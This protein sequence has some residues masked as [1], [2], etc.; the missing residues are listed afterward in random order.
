M[1]NFE[2]I[3]FNGTSFLIYTIYYVKEWSLSFLKH[4]EFKT[5]VN[6]NKTYLWIKF[7]IYVEILNT[8]WSS[9]HLR[10]IFD[11]QKYN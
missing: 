5:P 1:T 8:N 6:N 9:L 2:A 10:I 11:I 7:S 3:Q 4:M